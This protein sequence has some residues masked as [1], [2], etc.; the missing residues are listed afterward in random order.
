MPVTK[1][2]VGYVPEHFSSPLLILG[3]SAWGAE[4]L[5]LV[6]QPSGTGQMLSSLDASG[7]GGQVIDVAVALTESLIAPLAKGRDDYR[8]VG[9]Y[10]R[11]PLNW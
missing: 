6:S 8:L 3:R 10:V 1:L 5:E 11:S 2:R 7:A 9:S 4:H